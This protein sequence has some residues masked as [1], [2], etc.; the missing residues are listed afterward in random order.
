MPFSLSCPGCGSRLRAPDAAAGRALRCPKCDG[1]VVVPSATGP[2]ADFAF[3]PSPAAGASEDGQ[4]NPFDETEPG[5]DSVSR[6]SR[7]TAGKKK[8]AGF[9]PFDEADADEGA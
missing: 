1:P 3:T 8:P 2:A 7:K 9:N 5:D 4:A 6:T